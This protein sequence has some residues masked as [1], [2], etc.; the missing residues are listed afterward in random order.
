MTTNVRR[1]GSPRIENCILLHHSTAYQVTVQMPTN[2][3]ISS[4]L[5]GLDHLN[6]K[7]ADA[8]CLMG[9]G[10]LE[11]LADE[12]WWAACGIRLLGE[13]PG[14]RGLR[15][16]NHPARRAGPQPRPALRRGQAAPRRRPDASGPANA[17]RPMTSWRPRLT[18]SFRR[19]VQICSGWSSLAQALPLSVLNRQGIRRSAT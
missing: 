3:V 16:G 12:C 6:Q 4:G 2:L 13:D 17:R 14:Q 8:R 18:E 10:D 11:R 15:A 1:I 19:I 9:V 5:A 7:A